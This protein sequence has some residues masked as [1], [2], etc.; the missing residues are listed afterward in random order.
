MCAYPAGAQVPALLA[1]FSHFSQPGK[2]IAPRPT[3]EAEN[4][5][6]LPMFREHA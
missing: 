2:P 1:L 6:S 4:C 5:N 3:A